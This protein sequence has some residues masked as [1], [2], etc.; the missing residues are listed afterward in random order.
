MRA[1]FMPQVSSRL[2]ALTDSKG[3]LR[4]TTSDSAGLAATHTWHFETSACRS[5]L[6]PSAG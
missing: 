6:W 3:Q 2:T 4:S 1:R 5:A